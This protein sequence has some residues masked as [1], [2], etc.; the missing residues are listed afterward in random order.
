MFKLTRP[1]AISLAVAAGLL[2]GCSG[3]LGS[4]GAKATGTT[5][6][7][8]TT[9][10]TSTSATTFASDLTDLQG[11]SALSQ[12][13]ALNGAGGASGLVSAS[14]LT[15][16][17]LAY[18]VATVATSSMSAA[19][20]SQ[21]NAQSTWNNG[22]TIWSFVAASGWFNTSGGSGGTFL[23]TETVKDAS[24]NVLESNPMEM[25]YTRAASSSSTAWSGTDTV[26]ET[27]ANS[28]LRPSGT[29]LHVNQTDRTT[30]TAGD[31]QDVATQSVTFTPASGGQAV[32]TQAVVVETKGTN[33]SDNENRTYTGTLPGGQSFTAISNNLMGPATFSF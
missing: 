31:T 4:I 1:G 29:Y 18:Q 27:V 24:G 12:L 25:D 17:S 26:T 7:S 14:P 8:T 30:D 21:F 23:G 9:A 2:S 5:S 13:T 19:Q 28:L 6:T 33:G 32:Q 20:L 3:L 22:N 15:T 10:S 11:I 16:A